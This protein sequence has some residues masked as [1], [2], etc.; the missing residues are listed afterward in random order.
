MNCS[1][2]KQNHVAQTNPGLSQGYPLEIPD[3]FTPLFNGADFSGW[4]GNLKYFRI[5]DGTIK[6]GTLK[7][8]IPRNEFLCTIKDYSDFELD[9]TAFEGDNFDYF[10]DLKDYIDEMIEFGEYKKSSFFA[11]N[12]IRPGVESRF[13]ITY[14]KEEDCN[15]IFGVIQ[16]SFERKLYD[17]E[18]YCYNITSK[19]AT[20]IINSIDID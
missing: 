9:V 17:I 4:E 18:L 5:E 10:D 20:S 14:S 8:P 2:T 15:I 19:V 7:N 13:S 11:K 6:A 16:D 12:E 3:G 1:G